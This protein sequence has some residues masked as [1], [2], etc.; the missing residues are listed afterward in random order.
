MIRLLRIGSSNLN[1]RSMGL[2]AECDVAVEVTENDQSAGTTRT[3]IA[4]LRHTLLAEHLGIASETF[5]S[6]TASTGSLIG[7]SG[8]RA[9]P[10]HPGPHAGAAGRTYPG[11]DTQPRCR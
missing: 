7:R 11:R 5:A 4:S 1:N 2:D 6:A 8:D 3:A 10:P 9:V